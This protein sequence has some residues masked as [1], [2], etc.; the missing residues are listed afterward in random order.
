ML[1]NYRLSSGLCDALGPYFRHCV[2]RPDRR[3]MLR[4]LV[5]GS[6]NMRDRDFA[7]LLEGLKHQKTLQVLEYS[8]NELGPL[9]IA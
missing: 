8:N 5:L 7:A 6:N 1:S 4:K 3:F 9:S 2:N